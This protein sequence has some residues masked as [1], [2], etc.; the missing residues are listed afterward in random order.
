MKNKVLTA[1]LCAFTALLVITGSIALPIYVRPF[2]YCQIDALGIPADTGY[3][4]Q[5]IIEAYDEVLDYLTLPNREFGTGVFSHSAD[6]AA[7]F[8]DCKA[9]F[10]L[11]AIILLA[12]L[13]GVMVLQILR[14]FGVF[15]L[16]YFRGR[17]PAFRCGGS[18][19]LAFAAVGGLAALNFDR[20]FEVFHA[21]FF[22]GKD[23]WVFNYRADA[24]ILAMPQGFF[25]NCA[26]LIL[27]SVA[28]WS[29]VLIVYGIRHRRKHT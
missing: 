4:K 5:T 6:G 25:M 14:R 11:N 18:I 10:D 27:S 2:Y 3:D 24:I 16:Y 17:H 13:V 28:L 15:D 22:P 8:A 19:L 23:N 12:S 26:I 1:L 7:H 20:A 9:L 29:L 21:I